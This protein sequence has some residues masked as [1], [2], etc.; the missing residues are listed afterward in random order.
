GKEDE[1]RPARLRGRVQQVLGAGDIRALER[2]LGRTLLDDAGD[3]EDDLAALR[4]ADQLQRLVDVS[5]ERLDPL[6]KSRRIVI[7]M[8]RQQPH[9]VSGAQQFRD[10]RR[11]DHTGP[12]GDENLHRTSY[13]VPRRVK[14]ARRSDG[15]A[16]APVANR[17]NRWRI[18]PWCSLRA[19][20][21]PLMR[22]S[23]AADPMA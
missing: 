9:R 13:C 20:T 21:L 5:P 10:C 22:L 16:F 18:S 4:G 11:P 2:D 15:M 14:C 17:A 19:A 7:R 1:A 12:A 6:G 3:V 8:T 23:S